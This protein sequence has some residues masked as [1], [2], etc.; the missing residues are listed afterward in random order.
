MVRPVFALA[1]AVR[2]TDESIVDGAVEG[3]G[4]GAVGLGGLV[5]GWH[6][7][8]LPRAATAVLGGALVL[9]LAAIVLVGLR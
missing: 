2:R 5:A 7:A 4:T 9:G 1:R 3:T 8:G 6:R